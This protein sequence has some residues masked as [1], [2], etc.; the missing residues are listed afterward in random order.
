[1]KILQEIIKR[2]ENNKKLLQKKRK[3]QKKNV[4]TR[5]LTNGRMTNI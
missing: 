4:A 3:E 2:V 1:M 5:K